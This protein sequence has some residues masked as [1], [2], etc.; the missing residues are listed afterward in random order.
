MKPTEGK[1]CTLLCF[2]TT[3]STVLYIYKVPLLTHSSESAVWNT[4]WGDFLF[5]LLSTPDVCCSLRTKRCCVWHFSF[6]GNWNMAG[7]KKKKN[8]KIFA[9]YSPALPRSHFWSTDLLATRGV[10]MVIR[11]FIWLEADE[12]QFLSTFWFSKRKTTNCS[13]RL[14]VCV[15]ICGMEKSF[16]ES[17]T[18]DS[19][20]AFL[21]W[22]QYS[23]YPCFYS[24][25]TISE[26]ER[27]SLPVSLPSKTLQ[28]EV[29]ADEQICTEMKAFCL[30]VKILH[31][32]SIKQKRSMMSSSLC[33][34]NASTTGKT[35][36]SHTQQQDKSNNSSISGRKPQQNVNWA[37]CRSSVLTDSQSQK[38]WN[39][40]TDP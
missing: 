14:S 10:N 38:L 2:N 32:V 34:R 22:S 8:K 25:A 16:S 6:H 35:S 5:F 26:Y 19:C 13:E 11:A 7:W 33:C 20:R 23:V 12:L 21:W 18:D 30:S 4:R 17:M 29:S 39:I 36:S 31:K 9:Y 3:D 15:F 27:A 1:M 24:F 28:A 37:E 40:W